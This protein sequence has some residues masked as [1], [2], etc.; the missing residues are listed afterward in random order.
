M[1]SVTWKRTVVAC[2]ALLA[3][4]AGAQAALGATSAR[5]TSARSGPAASVPWT[6][7]WA[8]APESGG[9]SF[10]QQTLRQI[11]HTSIGGKSVRVEVSNV[12]GTAPLAITDVRIALRSSGSAIK[13][14]T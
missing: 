10:G 9:A 12:F 5:T 6:G 13:P 14:G 2:A 11:V 3:C 7:T 8:V 1:I 4:V